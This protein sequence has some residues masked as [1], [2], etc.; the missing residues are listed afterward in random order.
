MWIQDKIEEWTV[1][2]NPKSFDWSFER[3][4]L[5]AEQKLGNEL[6]KGCAFD[7]GEFVVSIQWSQYNYCDHYVGN[8]YFN[9]T[10]H[11][12]I[13]RGGYNKVWQAEI[14]LI[15]KTRY[16]VTGWYPHYYFVCFE[17][18]NK[19]SNILPYADYKQ[20]EEILQVCSDYAQA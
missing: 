16:K 8:S 12:P 2:Y 20:I 9:T 10:Y 6:V 7:F 5:Y 19:H 11:S 15:C 14:A 1:K 18:D 4:Y 13:V 3:P 17:E